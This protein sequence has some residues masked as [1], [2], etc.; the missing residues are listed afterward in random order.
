MKTRRFKKDIPP[1][2]GEE[3]GIAMDNMKPSGSCP[4]KIEVVVECYC[5]LINIIVVGV[6]P[7]RDALVYAPWLFF[8]K[9]SIGLAKRLD[10]PI[11]VGCCCWPFPVK[12]SHFRAFRLYIKTLNFDLAVK[13]RRFL[14]FLSH[15]NAKKLFSSKRRLFF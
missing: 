5:F 1:E 15:E 13:S 10:R 4:E 7:R 6:E 3:T 2:K 14:A 11:Y 9:I 12:V 8:F